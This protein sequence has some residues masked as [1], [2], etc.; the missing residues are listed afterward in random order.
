MSASVQDSHFG[1]LRKIASEDERNAIEEEIFACLA[2]DIAEG[3]VNCFEDLA[4]SHWHFNMA[5]LLGL[6]TF[7]N[8]YVTLSHILLR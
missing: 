4:I 6:Y 2:F 7:V 8:P 1:E 3:T 5:Q